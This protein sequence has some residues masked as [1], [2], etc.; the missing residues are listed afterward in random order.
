MSGQGD[1]VHRA[2]A[3]PACYAVDRATGRAQPLTHAVGDVRGGSAAGRGERGMR[4]RMVM[5]MPFGGC[6]S[7]R[8]G[9]TWTARPA[10]I[11]AWALAKKAR[12]AFLTDA[13]MP[14][15]RAHVTLFVNLVDGDH[16]S[17]HWFAHRD[18]LHRHLHPALPQLAVSG[19]SRG[20]EQAS[21]SR[22]VTPGMSRT[23]GGGGR[24]GRAGARGRGCHGPRR[25]RRPA[26]RG[27]CARGGR[28]RRRRTG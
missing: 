9:V 12:W 2:R 3:R 24:R 25:G 8:S 21:P 10:D 19:A 23:S 27:H 15:L 13:R 26:R 18:Q 22:Y 1:G 4:Q 20:R 11:K 5:A 6:H 14:V 28:G 7:S 16:R 17:G